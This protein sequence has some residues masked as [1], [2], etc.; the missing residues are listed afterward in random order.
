MKEIDKKKYEKN[1]EKIKLQNIMNEN[2]YQCV[3]CCFHSYSLTKY[4]I[5]CNSKKHLNNIEN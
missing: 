2:K 1:K 4:K 3:L 5:H